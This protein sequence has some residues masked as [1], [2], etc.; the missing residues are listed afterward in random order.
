MVSSLPWIT[1]CIGAQISALSMFVSPSMSYKKGITHPS[2]YNNVSFSELVHILSGTDWKV[3]V[4]FLSFC[5][6]IHT[7]NF[8]YHVLQLRFPFP[9]C[10]KLYK[11]CLYPLVTP[12]TL[13]CC[14]LCNHL[15]HQNHIQCIRTHI[16][17]HNPNKRN[18]DR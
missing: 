16:N 17:Y 2:K 11:F 1:F 12:F 8:I 3:V 15:S 13:L 9:I 5:P 18:A 7:F 4:T 10:F 14:L 6:L